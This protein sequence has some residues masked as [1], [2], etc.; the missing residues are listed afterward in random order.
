MNIN[1]KNCYKSVGVKYTQRSS[2]DLKISEFKREASSRALGMH[3]IIVLDCRDN[4]LI[5]SCLK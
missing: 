1:K 5:F 4:I 2:S 3:H